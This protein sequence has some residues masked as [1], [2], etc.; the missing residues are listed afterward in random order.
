MIADQ[1]PTTFVFP[2][3]NIGKNEINLNMTMTTAPHLDNQ[4]IT[5]NFD[6]MFVDKDVHTKNSDITSYPPRIQ[7]D[8]SN[9]FWIHE[10]MVNSLLEDLHDKAF[11]FATKS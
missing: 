9:Q 2:I 10:D 8:R 3:T 6:G 5:L 11:P 7:N 1:G 4:I